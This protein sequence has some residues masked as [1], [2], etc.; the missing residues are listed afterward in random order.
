MPRSCASAIATSFSG[1]R[2]ASRSSTATSMAWIGRFDAR[3]ERPSRCIAHAG[4]DTRVVARGPNRV[5]RRAA[6]TGAGGR[7]PSEQAPGIQQRSRAGARRRRP[8]PAGSDPAAD[9]ARPSCCRCSVGESLVGY[10]VADRARG[11]LFQRRRDQAAQP[12]RRRH[13]VRARPHREG[14]AAQLPRLLRCADRFAE[15][16]AVQRSAG[17]VGARAPTAAQA[18]VAVLY[19]DIAALSSG[20]RIV[21]PQRGRRRAAG[22]GETPRRHL[23]RRGLARARGRERIR[24][25]A[26]RYPDAAQVAHLLETSIGAGGGRPGADRRPGSQ[27]GARL[28]HCAF[29]RRRDRSGR[30]AAQCRGSGD[31]G[32]ELGRRLPVLRTGHERAGGED[33]AA[34]KQAAPCARQ[35]RVRTALPAEARPAHA[36]RGRRSRRSSA[37]TIPTAGS[38]RRS[39]SSP[40]WRKRG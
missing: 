40:Y 29:S 9:I 27:A 23:A 2:A 16:H 34:G 14:G 11:R 30:V 22:S 19:I 35:R 15:P 31:Q 28:R 13:L 1:R 6:R 33:A 21:R 32:Q 3:H 26:G 37:G 38:S 25:D 17:A 5:R 24:R 18:R 12:A 20:Q 36:A 7:R 10:P 4:S 8:A 39:N